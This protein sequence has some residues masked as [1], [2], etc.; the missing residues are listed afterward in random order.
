MRK[1]IR[2]SYNE[3][4]QSDLAK[5]YFGYW[6]R[7]FLGSRGNEKGFEFFN[8]SIIPYFSYFGDG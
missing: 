2:D 3:Y 5:V 1:F 8:F 4:N 7:D 6:R